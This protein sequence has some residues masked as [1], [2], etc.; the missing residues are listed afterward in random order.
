VTIIN[1][2]AYVAPNES[3]TAKQAIHWSKSKLLPSRSTWWVEMK[4]VCKFGNK[5]TVQYAA[6]DSSGTC[7][8]SL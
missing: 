8:W 7:R 4:T 3:G 6:V 2:S 5:C 1:S